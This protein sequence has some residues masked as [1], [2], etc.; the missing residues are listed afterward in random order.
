MWMWH[1]RGCQVH[2]TFTSVYITVRDSYILLPS[3]P[4]GFWFFD[5]YSDLLSFF[6]LPLYIL[7]YTSLTFFFVHF[8]FSFVFFWPI[9]ISVTSFTSRAKLSRTLINYLRGRSPWFLIGFYNHCL[10]LFNWLIDWLDWMETHE[11]SNW[12]KYWFREGL[13]AL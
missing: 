8:P 9:S 5:S 12:G 13:W 3:K 4:R 7:L 11:I 10:W 6:L 1:E 2:F